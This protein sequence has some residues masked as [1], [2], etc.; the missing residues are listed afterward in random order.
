MSTLEADVVIVGGGLAGGVAALA[1][2]RRGARVLLLEKN[3]SPGGV[4][5]AARVHSMLTF[6]GREGERIVGGIPQEIIDRLKERGGTCGHILDTIG[7]AHSVTPFDPD[8]LGLLLQEMLDEAGV[9]LLLETSFTGAKV[10][11]QRIE[12]VTFF[13]SGG[14]GEARAPLYIDA[15]GEGA[16]AARAG[17]PFERGR[18]GPVMPATLIFSVRSIDLGKVCSYMESHHDEFHGETL[19]SHVRKTPALGVSGF[20][21]LWR[22]AALPVPRDRL[23]FYQTLNSDEVSINS[24]RV[25]GYDPLDNAAA[26]GAYRAAREQVFQI[27]RFLRSSVPGFESSVISAV[28][29]SLGL[30]EVRRIRGDYVLTGEDV[31]KGARFPDEVALGGFPVDIHLPGASGIETVSLGG[32]GFYGVPYRCLLPAGAANLL[33]VGKCFSASFEAHASGRVQATAMATGHAAGAA[34]A[35]ALRRKCSPRELDAGE[36]RRELAEEGAILEPCGKDDLP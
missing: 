32:R 15:S 34:C 29:P 21:T 19:F 13:S 6:H 35:L 36:V 22:E 2:A 17:C 20:F 12:A 14:H 30:R 7:V 9:T 23:L 5:V 25:L 3:T 4:A 11:S 26:A 24:T 33:V 8:S 28:A 18:A 31:V 27:F 16:L 10:S 1:A